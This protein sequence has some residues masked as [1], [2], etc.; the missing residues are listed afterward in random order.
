MK[1]VD[2]LVV[3]D[4]A[5]VAADLAAQL[6][7]LHYKVPA[8]V[9][10]GEE[11]LALVSRMNPGLVLMDIKLAGEVDGIEAH[12]QRENDNE[13]PHFCPNSFS[14]HIKYSFPIR[15]QPGL[16]SPREKR[17]F[18]VAG[19]ETDVE[20]DED[21]GLGGQSMPAAARHK[22]QEPHSGR[23]WHETY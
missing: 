2:V 3:E 6:R 10:T 19:I 1:S 7:R 12:Q 21:C 20:W 5:I 15:K 4:E 8:V 11:A 18:R 23:E 14:N 17:F 13:Y 22:K 16:A 9:S